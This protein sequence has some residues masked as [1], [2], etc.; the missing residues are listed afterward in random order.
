MNNQHEQEAREIREKIEYL[1]MRSRYWL[2]MDE[3]LNNTALACLAIG[4][5]AIKLGE[6][7][8][9]LM[10]RWAHDEGSRL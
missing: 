1:L 6:Q 9:E 4:E 7:A 10:V 5:S 8:R 2:D 3:C